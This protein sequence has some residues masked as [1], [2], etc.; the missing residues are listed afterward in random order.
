MTDSLEIVKHLF[1]DHLQMGDKADALTADSQI[2]GALPWFDSLAIVNLIT[3]LEE[4]Y[5]LEIDDDEINGELFETVG[6]LANFVAAKL[7]G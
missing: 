6:S 1:K 5:G 7:D 3:A 2:A 4:Q